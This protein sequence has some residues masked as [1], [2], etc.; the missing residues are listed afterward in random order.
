MRMHSH[1]T[2]AKLTITI[3]G[4]KNPIMVHKVLFYMPL[5]IPARV[6]T[7]LD[8]VHIPRFALHTITPANPALIEYKILVLRLVKLQC[9]I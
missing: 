5:P 8:R 4:I 7:I 1:S 9:F 3:T 6:R 2:C